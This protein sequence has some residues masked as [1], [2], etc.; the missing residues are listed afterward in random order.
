MMV[1]DITALPDN[2]VVTIDGL[3]RHPGEDSADYHDRA[4]AW[5]ASNPGSGPAETRYSLNRLIVASAA[6]AGCLSI[7]IGAFILA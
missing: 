6:Y 5:M 2:P 4:L 7:L 1:S 3:E